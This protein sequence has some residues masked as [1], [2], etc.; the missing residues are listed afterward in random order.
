M[1]HLEQDIAVVLLSSG[2]GKRGPGGIARRDLDRLQVFRFVFQPERNLCEKALLSE[3]LTENRLQISAQAPAV[4]RLRL[5]L[6]DA[7]D[8]ALLNELAFESEEWSELVVPGL[9]CLHLFGNSK[10]IAQEILDVR[11]KRD[12]QLGMFLGRPGAWIHARV[13]KL[14]LQAE[15]RT[16]KAGLES[17]VQTHKPISGIEILKTEAK[18]ERTLLR[19]SGI[20]CS[21]HFNIYETDGRAAE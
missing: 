13:K 14:R 6:A 8:R 5:L 15:H 9:Q 12:H 20:G 1:R 17:G 16:T 2:F 10:Q 18:A 11:R 21:W 19:H 3:R 7:A 4:D